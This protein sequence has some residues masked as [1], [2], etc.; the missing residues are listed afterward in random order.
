MT[1][2]LIETGAILNTRVIA[3]IVANKIR[4]GDGL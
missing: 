3:E 1:V 2:N 4:K